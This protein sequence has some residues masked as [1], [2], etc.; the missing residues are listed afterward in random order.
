MKPSLRRSAERTDEPLILISDDTDTLLSAHNIC[1]DRNPLLYPVTAA[2]IDKVI[3]AVKAKP[4]T[5]AI[6]AARV[7]D[8][9]CL[10]QDALK[11][12]AL[13]V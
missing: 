3:P 7:D 4:T 1:A 12:P 2:N 8:P 13:K 10:S 5:V 9:L 11:R 6:K